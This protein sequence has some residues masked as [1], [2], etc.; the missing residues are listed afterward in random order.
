[1]EAITGQRFKQS[2]KYIRAFIILSGLALMIIFLIYLSILGYA[3]LLGPPPLSVPKSSIFYSADGSVLG[4]TNTSQKRY[5]VKLSD[6]SPALVEA[7]VSV[8]DQH[9]FEHGGFDP[10]RIAGAILADLHAM[11]KVQG[12]STITQQY[13]RNLFLQHDK[14]WKRKLE[15]AFYTIRIEM[16]YSKEEILEG[17]LNTIYYGHGSYGV[18]AAS[19]YYFGKAAENLTVAEASMLAGI[20][21]GPSRYS[22]FVSEQNAKERQKI[23]L[24]AMQ[25]NGYLN[26]NETVQAY[27][28][29]LDFK[30]QEE[31]ADDQFA[32]YFQ[33]AVKQALRTQLHLDER[34]IELGGLSIYTTLDANM[35]KEAEKNFEE[36]ISKNTDIQGSLVSMNPKTG[37]VKAM[38]GGRDYSQSS[39]NRATQASRQPGSTMKPILYYAALEQGFTPSTQ[40]R[41]ELTTF[42]YDEGKSSYTPHNFNNQYADEDITM[43]QA[44]ALSDNVYAVKTHLFLKE[45]SLINTA[46]RFG[47]ESPLSNVPSLALGTSGVKVL[48]MVNAYSM[49]ANGGKKV[50]PIFISKVV[51]HKGEII[52]EHTPAKEKV[53]DP[54]L[55]FEMTSLLTGMFDQ[56]LNGYSSVT[57]STIASQLTRPYAGKSGS[58]EYD[59]WMIGFTPQ[60]V[61]GVWTGYD[62]SKKIV[63]SIEKRYSKSIW[64]GFMENALA[65]QPVK[66][67]KPSANVVG[68]YVNPASGKLATENCPVSRLTYYV[69]GTEPS[70]YCTEHLGDKHSKQ[71]KH[72]KEKKVPWYKRIWGHE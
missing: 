32:P 10:K 51:N 14:T 43:A 55:A 63:S 53:L 35:Q 13:A 59:S 66:K 50:E 24:G 25:S 17:Y 54:D 28:E 30:G 47:I 31:A 68:V 9:F 48:E 27:S 57:G 64:A 22:P 39:F 26:K 37:E 20:P 38:V 2:F 56:K 44:L 12:A 16:N 49:F 40:L 7:T 23:V 29:Q 46:R 36:V 4:E 11:A 1:M 8:E 70:E 58:T 71:E 61:T 62:D 19:K 15:E 3:K 41:S 21:K 52:Y 33:D 34:S 6:I 42:T 69:K 72:H 65:D 5:W 45:N 18:Q 60:L 67:F